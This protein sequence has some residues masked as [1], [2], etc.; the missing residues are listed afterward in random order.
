MTKYFEP[1]F[2]SNFNIN[3]HEPIKEESLI[4]NINQPNLNK[5]RNELIEQ[6]INNNN[7]P[8]NCSNNNN[9]FR[10]KR[11]C[12]SPNLQTVKIPTLNRY[13]SEPMSSKSQ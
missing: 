1:V 13:Y 4:S 2:F 12:I 11:K 3:Y 8:N 10:I 7:N 5:I 9:N 6:Y